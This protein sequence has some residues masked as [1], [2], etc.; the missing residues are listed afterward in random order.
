M[1]ELNVK[2]E[3]IPVVV[4][5]ASNV[6]GTDGQKAVE[7]NGDAVKTRPLKTAGEMQEQI[8]TEKMDDKISEK[9][10]P[11]NE[12]TQKSNFFYFLILSLNIQWIKIE[13]FYLHMSN[14]PTGL[15][16]YLILFHLHFF[17]PY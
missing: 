3:N 17:Q 11:V 8:K 10:A 5:T 6:S 7:L 14:C 16:L 2:K 12:N 13:S 9:I 1:S 15:F 4:N